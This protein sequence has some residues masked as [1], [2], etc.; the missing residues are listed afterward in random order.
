[1][2]LDKNKALSNAQKYIQRGQIDKAIKE[3]ES[4]VQSDPSDMRVWLKIGDL[5]SRT[6]KLAEAVSTYKRVAESHQDRGFLLKAVAVYKKVLDVDPTLIEIHRTLGDVYAK[7]N[8][9]NEAL[10]Q[11]RQVVGSYER[12]GRTDDSMMLLEE[13]VELAPSNEANHLRLA[14]AH[15]KNC[16]DD[17]AAEH[18][19]IVLKRMREQARHAEFVKVGERLL[20]LYPTEYSTGRHL[21]QAYLATGNTRRALAWLQKLFRSDPQDT[22]TLAL[23]AQTFGEIGKIAKATAVYRELARIYGQDGDTVKQRQA[24][25]RLLALV[26]DD[27][28]ALD[29]L[30][31]IEQGQMG[32]GAPSPHL[33]QSLTGTDTNFEAALPPSDRVELCLSDVDLLMKYDL[34]SHA[35]QRV[36]VAIGLDPRNPAIYLKQAAI[37]SAT[38]DKARASDALVRAAE[39]QATDDPIQAMD[40]LRE[41]M[42]LVPGHQAASALLES[43]RG[44]ISTAAPAAP[45]P[46]PETQELDPFDFEDLSVDLDIELNLDDLSLDGMDN[47]DDDSSEFELS[48]EGFD[49]DDLGFDMSDAELSSAPEDDEFGDLLGD[50]DEITEMS[51]IDDFEIPAHQRADANLGAQLSDVVTADATTPGNQGVLI[52]KPKQPPPL[53]PELLTVSDDDVISDLSFDLS[54]ENS[55]SNPEENDS[56]SEH[57]PID[58]SEFADVDLNQ[59]ALDAMA[60]M[61]DDEGLGGLLVD[62]PE[63]SSPAPMDATRGSS[64]EKQDED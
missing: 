11:Y 31:E 27:Q 4:I 54:M 36:D 6:G 2:A 58:L 7:L 59:A 3:Y 25:Q 56:T 44:P 19:G 55:A 15:A 63:T 1:M 5:H 17:R 26:P 64:N 13:M 41:A 28:A 30:T 46:L 35:L 20:Y 45:P 60:H 49:L 61:D 38:N 23:L 32:R 24:L 8:L 34:P 22:R 39:I 10:A 62:T 50:D 16:N 29:A 40:Y 42:Q 51:V 9:T 47:P 53:R 43:L 18:F 48:L 52:P 33:G 57:E 21:A 12:D 37:C 14:E